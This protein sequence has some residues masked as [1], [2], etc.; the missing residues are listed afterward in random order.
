MSSYQEI[1]QN[2][3]LEVVIDQ[4]S[5]FC[6][7]VERAINIAEGFLKE[8]KKLFTAGDIVHND[9]EIKRL[10]Y[11][12]MQTID[13][14]NNDVKDG[15]TVLFRAHGEPP[16]S[17]ERMKKQGINVI[18]ATC[19]IVVK[20]QERVKKA[21]DEVKDEDG[22]IV[23]YGKKGHAEIIGLLGQ[24]DGQAIII[25]SEEDI[26]Q[27]DKSK[28]TVL[29]SQTTKSRT[30]LDEM[31]KHIINHLDDSDNLKVNRTICGQVG[32]RVPH[33]KEFAKDFD[34]V[35]FVAGA[36]SSNGKVLYEVCKSVNDKSFFA[37]NIEDIR[38]E[39][40]KPLPTKIGVCGATSTPN[41]LMENIAE[42]IS[43]KWLSLK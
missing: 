38:E 36:K 5:G 25:E 35:V 17:Y 33:L 31:E 27:L 7:G 3:G 19:P 26:K 10:T 18:D 8:N 41:W 28:K 42:E 23:I 12:G 39:W 37:S 9:E 13:V 6:F 34:I 11:K 43:K 40:L 14:N 22:Q 29:F 24:T 1:A 20:L 21:W 32:N 16:A 2:S 30:G 4:K 15:E